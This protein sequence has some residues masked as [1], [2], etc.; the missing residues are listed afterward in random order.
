MKQV[1]QNVNEQYSYKGQTVLVD[2]KDT[3]IQDIK[4]N[5]NAQIFF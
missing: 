3:Q 1:I 4:F 2:I 5:I